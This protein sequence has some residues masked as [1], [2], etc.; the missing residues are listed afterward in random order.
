MG[1]EGYHLVKNRRDQD[2]V[3]PLIMECFPE[4]EEKE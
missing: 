3:T 4:I 2:A 1:Y